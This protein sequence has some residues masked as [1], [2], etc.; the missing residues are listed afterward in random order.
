MSLHRPFRTALAVLLLGAAAAANL[1]HPEA[2]RHTAEYAIGLWWNH[3][4]PIMLPGYVL[5]QSLI[6]LIPSRPLYGLTILSL[7]TFPPL[8]AAVFWDWS[9]RSWSS[10][11]QLVPLLLYTNL[12][13]PLF[14]P[15]P[16]LG[17]LLDG[18]LYA[19]AWLLWPLL[20]ESLSPVPAQDFRP[21]QWVLDGMNWT[22]IM[23]F[24]VVMAWLMHSWV[25]QVGVGWLIDPVGIRWGSQSP[26]SWWILFW[27]AFGGIGYWAPFLYRA[28]P[29]VRMRII[30]Y[31]LAQAFIASGLVMLS[32]LATR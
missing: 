10:S 29:G 22:T 16:R 20:R 12:Y 8:A 4:V 21:R 15:R 32:G 14:F 23:G 1:V 27:T 19:S 2:T 6:F 28:G 3:L 11:Q 5:A 17:I 30:G 9:R 7:F 18:A 26:S 13:N 24:V 25:P 31:R